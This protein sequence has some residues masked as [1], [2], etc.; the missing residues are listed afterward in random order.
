MKKRNQ[1]KTQGAKSVLDGHKKIGNRLKPEFLT[2]INFQFVSYV[3]NTIPEIILLGLLNDAHG[4]A[5]GAELSLA[6]SQ[7]ILKIL[8]DKALISSDLLDMSRED[9]AR[10][11]GSLAPEGRTAVQTALTPFMTIFPDHPVSYFGS[12]GMDESVSIGHFKTCVGR[13]YDRYSVPACAALANL[14]YTQACA[15]RIHIAEGL[16][17][18][19]LDAIIASPDSDDGQHAS[20][21]VRMHAQMFIGHLH[22]NRGEWPQQF[23][24]RCYTVSECDLESHDE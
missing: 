22:E 15:G 9:A 21:S 4:Y 20:S 1:S 5:R 10:V 19:N 11:I 23:W 14:Y 6:L 12:V 3:D 7:S 17:V 18:P 2:K 13:L 8:P 16:R 24:N